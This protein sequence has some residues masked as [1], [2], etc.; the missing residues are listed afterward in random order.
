M[1]EY[2]GLRR[3]RGSAACLPASDFHCAGTQNSSV[4]RPLFQLT[5][6]RGLNLGQEFAKS[7]RKM[8][9]LSRHSFSLLSVEAFK[10]IAEIGTS[11]SQSEAG[12][13]RLQYVCAV[14]KSVLALTAPTGE[15]VVVVVVLSFEKEKK[16]API[17]VRLCAA[18]QA[19]GK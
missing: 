11:G 10:Y 4:V 8:V 19:R 16:I 13:F 5:R 3:V 18:C 7:K 12:G 2:G 1:S 15:P 14:I 6:E 17:K 9:R